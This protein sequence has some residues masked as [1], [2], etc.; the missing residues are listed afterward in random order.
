MVG[1]KKKKKITDWKEESTQV[2]H[3]REERQGERMGQRRA[4]STEAIELNTSACV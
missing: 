2:Y 1:K 4:G 3:T